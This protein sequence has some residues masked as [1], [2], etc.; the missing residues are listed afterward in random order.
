MNELA[1]QH[2]SRCIPAV[3]A[4]HPLR[5]W[6]WS[7]REPE[8][9]RVRRAAIATLVRD[10]ARRYPVRSLAGVRGRNLAAAR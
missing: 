10:V 9:A 6:N 1:D 3:P 4:R 2:G 8:T 7:S 5:C